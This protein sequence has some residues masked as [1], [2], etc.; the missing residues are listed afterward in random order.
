MPVAGT[1]PSAPSHYLIR[2]FRGPTVRLRSPQRSL[3]APAVGSLRASAASPERRTRSPPRQ[4]LYS[5]AQK[6]LL[7]QLHIRTPDLEFE[8]SL[9]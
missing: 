9:N 3:G 8:W 4:S 2:E 5:G 6:R 7:P 1:E